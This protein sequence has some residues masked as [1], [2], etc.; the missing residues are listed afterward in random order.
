VHFRA[1]LIVSLAAPALWAQSAPAFEVASVKPAVQDDRNGISFFCYPGGRITVTKF[2]LKQLVEIAYDVQPHEVLG[3]PQ[4][5]D[6]DRFDIEARPAATSEA[7]KD[8]PV[9]PKSPPSP[10][11]RRMVQTLLADRFQLKLHRETRESPVLILVATK[12][13]HKLTPTQ[14][15]DERPFVGVYRTGS[16]EQ[17]AITIILAGNNAP[18]SLLTTEL[19]R[20]FKRPV[21]DK[22]ELKGSYDFRVEFAAQDD[23]AQPAPSIYAAMQEQLG[24]KLESGKGQAEVL[25]IDHVQKLA[26]N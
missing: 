3:V 23:P 2:T 11:V 5:M 19:A 8:R 4:W 15:P 22:T 16:V 1:L 20:R 24:L 18:V 17:P 13:G 14:K 26:V 7:S 25:V 9:S 6:V 21:F 10:E 12:G